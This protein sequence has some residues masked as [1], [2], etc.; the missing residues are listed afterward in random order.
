[1]LALLAKDIP[2][3]VLAGEG[4]E[5]SSHENFFVPS[6]KYNNSTI[7]LAAFLRAASDGRPCPSSLLPK[8]CSAFMV[9]EASVCL[10]L[11]SH[12]ALALLVL[13]QLHAQHSPEN[14]WG[15]CGVLASIHSRLQP[16]VIVLQCHVNF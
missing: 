10:L 1:M 12:K 4:A 5:S 7:C 9:P 6:C 13:L 3:Y 16:P 8:D 15:Q 11:V 14:L 2:H